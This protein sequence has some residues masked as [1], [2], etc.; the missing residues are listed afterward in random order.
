MRTVTSVSPF[1]A[2]TKSTAIATSRCSVSA[3]RAGLATI[4]RNQSAGPGA[5]VTT[6]GVTN[7]TTAGAGQVGQGPC[8]MNA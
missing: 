2:V 4:A 6:G 5:I 3:K 7:P 8:V 1:P